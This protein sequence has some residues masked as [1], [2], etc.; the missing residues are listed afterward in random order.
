MKTIMIGGFAVMLGVLTIFGVMTAIILFR[1]KTTN[2]T[3]EQRK[4]IDYD[5]LGEILVY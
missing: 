5:I 1:K 3:T 4:G 2:L